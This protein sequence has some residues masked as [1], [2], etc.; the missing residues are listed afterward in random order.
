[1]RLK[2][3]LTL[4]IG[5][6]FTLI[7]VMV[8]LS[9]VYIHKLSN[10]TKSIL[11]ANYNTLE[12]SRKMLMALDESNQD[13]RALVNF[14]FNL[15]AQLNNIT[16]L[17]EE[18]ATQQLRKNFEAY[19]KDPNN[20]SIHIAIRKDLNEIMN[21]NMRAI[22]RKNAIA[23]STSKTA[24]F[25]IAISGTLC[26]VIAF[27]VLVSFPGHVANPIKQ[28][29]ES[30]EQIA[31]K[32]Y[33]QRLH[34]Y[35]NDEFG[36][37][38]RAFNSM[39]S[40]LEEFENSS[41]AEILF[42][43]KRIEMII[44]NMND[45]ILIIDENKKILFIN[46]E[47][48][49]ILGI[50]IKNIE[51]KSANEVALSNDLMRSLM[52]DLVNSENTNRSNSLKIFHN[53]KES[54]FEKEIIPIGI[55]PTGEE[56]AIELGHVLILK[57]ITPFKE[58]D[59]AKTNFIATV[60]HELK[61]PISS[62]LL[63]TKLLEDQRIGPT[64]KDQEQLIHNIRD[65]SERLL[66]ITGELLKMTRVETGS[67]QLNIQTALPSEIIQ[68]AIDSVKM[69][70][71]QKNIGIEINIDKNIPTVQ[72]DPEKTTW[73]MIN[74]ISNAIRYSREHS[75]IE[76]SA[77]QKGETVEFS[78]KDFG[79][80]IPQE[81]QPKLFDKYFKVPGSHTDGSGLGLAISKDFIE[82]QGGKISVASEI[83]IGSEFT[84]A[85]QIAKT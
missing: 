23:Q 11:L 38:A 59:T 79:K 36:D 34:F 78:V 7:V 24:T 52:L 3:K 32:N 9:S 62:I 41:L 14:E 66:K 84:I 13:K 76:V 81:Y 19:K 22:V 4:G 80:G 68:Y 39:A 20:L 35:E 49:G 63:S 67:I 16:E 85:L 10:E 6:L 57:N 44:N 27:G 30:I 60:S 71:E 5:V 51:G 61:T 64:N 31:Q 53:N 50:D 33:T 28:L 45:P 46:Q 82:A 56:E 54:Y 69:Q 21:L 12:Y 55:K 70:A 42:E 8:V 47:A 65:D 75:K 48:K 43:K 26:F 58:L 77:K 2:T 17:G 72:S 18:E 1:M 83:G 73:V 15:N 25:W 29:T 37:L 74:L 40:K